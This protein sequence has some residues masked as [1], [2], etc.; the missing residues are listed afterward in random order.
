[1]RRLYRKKR[2]VAKHSGV[3]RTWV[4]GVPAATLGLGLGWSRH[5]F[6]VT[7]LKG[8][9]MKRFAS[10]ICAALAILVV[11]QGA[12]AG[13]GSCSYGGYQPWWNIFA[14]RNHCSKEEQRLQRFWH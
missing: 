1:M 12:Q 4:Q 5:I 9:A 6:R 13:W 7:P 11:S 2:R 10:F 14:P 8:D 3:P